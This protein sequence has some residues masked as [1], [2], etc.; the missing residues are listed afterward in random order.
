MLLVGLGCSGLGKLGSLLKTPSHPSVLHTSLHVVLILWGERVLRVWIDLCCVAVAVSVISRPG[1]NL[2][3]EV[4]KISY[5][6]LFFPPDNSSVLGDVDILLLSLLSWR[7]LYFFFFFFN[8][9][10]VRIGAVSPGPRS[11]S[12]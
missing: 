12:A 9:E 5:I 7:I 6:T 2:K 10:G 3:V 1:R 11:H 4:S 8:A